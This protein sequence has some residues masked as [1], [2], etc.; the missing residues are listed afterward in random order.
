MHFFDVGITTLVINEGY[1]MILSV[2][3]MSNR[4]RAIGSRLV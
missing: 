2:E 4:L 3:Q 1:L